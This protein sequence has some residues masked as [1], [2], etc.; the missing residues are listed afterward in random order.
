M[1]LKKKQKAS[2][3]L[4][5][6]FI[7]EV[8]NQ[9]TYYAFLILIVVTLL[10][11]PSLSFA[12]RA[13]DMYYTSE[14]C[15]RNLL[16]SPVKQKYRD[17]WMTCIDGFKKVYTYNPKGTWA[18]AG[19]Y[20]A[21]ELYLKLHRRSGKASDKQEARDLFE[22]IIKRF[23]NS[24]YKKRAAKEIAKNW[25]KSS[26]TKATA[27]K[28]KTVITRKR[29][30]LKSKKAATK[31]SK[32]TKTSSA[33]KGK[34]TPK[35]PSRIEDLIKTSSTDKRS[36]EAADHVQKP[37]GPSLVKELRH[38]SNPLYTRVVIDA[39]SAIT[40][41]HSLLKKDPSINKPPRLIIDLQNSKL[42]SDLKKKIP[43][44]DDLLKSIRAGQYK[45]E[46]V[47]VVMDIKSFD[48]Y[49]VFSLRN[50]F[51]IV[52]DIRG[53]AKARRYQ[54]KADKKKTKKS[55]TKQTKNV[56]TS[57]KSI[58]KGSLAKQL[59][60]GVKTIVIDPGHGGKDYGAPG[61]RRGVHEKD[62]ALAISK[63]LAKEIKKKLK[64][65]TVLTRTKDRFLTLEE[66]TAIANTKNADLFISIHTNANKVRQAY[67]IETYF[68]NLATDNES[69]MVAA[70][71]NATS[72]KNISDLQEILNDLMQNAKINESS[73]LAVQVQ[74]SIC[75]KL[76]RKYS[77]IRNKG[78]KQAPFYVLLGAQ[79]PAILIETSFISNPRECKRLVSSSYQDRL[80]KA[81]THGLEGYI[82][83]IHPTAFKH[84]KKGSNG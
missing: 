39:D 47:R 34:T 75:S 37:S 60:L 24:V 49:K 69:I 76:K 62:I 71:E 2:D 70:R 16:D 10:A 36:I 74:S 77:K 61:Y 8:K 7:I 43:I 29:Y 78:V 80:C 72:M 3:L 31:K 79:M 51:R 45:P 4:F 9:T 48:N 55:S 20:R 19:L 17:R 57:P 1:N 5:K 83:E 18:S 22:R 33:S 11:A 27:K 38:W 84:D 13:K 40:Y 15:R 56:V 46:T 23:P 52:I 44:N 68:L 67:G 63:K 65:V 25:K 32:T 26:K 30:V 6:R 50:P 82:E 73:R 42:S 66:R 59:A 14:M 35:N 58:P 54:L 21:G 28:K 64:C 81:I 53:R 12:N 41:R